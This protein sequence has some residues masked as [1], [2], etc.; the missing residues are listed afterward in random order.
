MIR[1]RIQYPQGARELKWWV[2]MKKQRFQ[3]YSRWTYT[4]HIVD[5]CQFK[6]KV[7]GLCC[8][9][10]AWCH[11]LNEQV[12]TLWYAQINR[13]KWYCY[14]L[15]LFAQVIDT[16]T[17]WYAQDPGPARRKIFNGSEKLCKI[18]YSNVYDVESVHVLLCII[19]YNN[20][21]ELIEIWSVSIFM[22]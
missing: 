12:D 1:H 7:L 2:K 17:R 21:S 8:S 22:P 18:W 16:R 11:D 9:H 15:Y 6:V 3:L 20:F 10:P 14:V 4:F 19:F 5:K 13:H